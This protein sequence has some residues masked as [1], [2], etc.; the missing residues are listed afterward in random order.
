MLM[1][2]FE[3]II[4]IIA[5]ILGSAVFLALIGMMRSG[6]SRKHRKMDAEET[7]MIQEMHQN[8]TR[9]E[10]RIDAL[11]TILLERE[12]ATRERTE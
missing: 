2:P 11:E 3:F 10:S 8:L 9:L 6:G 4:A 5:M 1:N 12:H 7:R